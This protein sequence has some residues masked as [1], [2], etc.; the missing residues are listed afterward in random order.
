MEQTPQGTATNKVGQQVELGRPHEP[1]P[2]ERKQQDQTEKIDMNPGE[3]ARPYVGGD[4]PKPRDQ[5]R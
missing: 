2:N 1:L 3:P 5:Q 4:N